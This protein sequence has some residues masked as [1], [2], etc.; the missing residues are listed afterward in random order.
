MRAAALALTILAAA[1][2]LW[3]WLV[4]AMI[5]APPGG[6]DELIHDTYYAVM[7]ANFRLPYLLLALV[8]A[9]AVLALAR[10]EGKSGAL[11]FVL[12]GAALL[13]AAAGMHVWWTEGVAPTPRVPDYADAAMPWQIWVQ[14]GAAW[15]AVLVLIVGW[16]V[17]VG[18]RFRA[19]RRME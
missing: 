10:G 14:Y 2:A 16:A 5:V 11:W 12:T 18:G 15:L 17:Y 9:A 4:A 1:A 19:R 3:S 13:M 6:A 7:G 8:N